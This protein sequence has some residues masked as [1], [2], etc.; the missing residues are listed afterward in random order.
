M[1][2][3]KDTFKDEIQSIGLTEKEIKDLKKDGEIKLEYKRLVEIFG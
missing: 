2:E 1:K 3:L